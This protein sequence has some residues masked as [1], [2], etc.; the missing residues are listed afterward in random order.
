MPGNGA[1]LLT[2]VVD[3]PHGQLRSRG[4]EE[5]RADL[6]R[7]HDPGLLATVIADAPD[8]TEVGLGAGGEPLQHWVMRRT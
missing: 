6:D 7:D 4:S 8:G 1:V 2:I 3:D 5:F